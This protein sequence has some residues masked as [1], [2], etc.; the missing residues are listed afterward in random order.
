LDPVTAIQNRARFFKQNNITDGSGAAA[1]QR[2]ADPSGYAVKVN[3][4]LKGLG[5]ALNAPVTGG[6]ALG[7]GAETP[8]LPAPAPV[9]PF[10]D[11]RAGT[12]SAR[13]K[14][15]PVV[16]EDNVDS[17]AATSLRDRTNSVRDKREG[18][19]T[20]RMDALTAAKSETVAAGPTGPNPAAP[21]PAGDQ[22]Y[23]QILQV[24]NQMGLRIDGSNQTTGGSHTAGSNHYAGRAVD[25]GDAKNDPEKLK[26]LA[27]WARR[28]APRIKEF[29][30]DPL[31]WYIRDG[32]IIK[33]S[34]GGH[35]DHAHIAM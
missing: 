13:E 33:G 14:L 18:L 32:K 27:A 19:A 35:G 2:P 15:R 34:I 23:K 11:R 7:L 20:K 9:N 10:A 25:Y 17:V 26:R 31:G 29:Y 28:N 3:N 24:G 1:L 6:P 12:Q 8:G 22:T 4:A 21:A 16:V 30:Y 5:A